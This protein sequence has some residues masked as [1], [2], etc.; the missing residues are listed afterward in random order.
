[1]KPLWQVFRLIWQAQR[2][3]LLRG[4]VL[5]VVVL[6]AGVTLLGV[7]GWFITAAAAAGLAGLGAVFDVFRPSGSIRFLALGRTAARY[8]ERVL[9]H[10]ATLR[11]FATL[12]LRVLQAYLAAPYDRQSRLRGPQVLNRITADI[13]A[14]DG[15]PLRLIL[16]LIAGGV[17]LAASFVVLWA[18]AGIAIAGVVAVGFALGGAV[19]LIWAGRAANTPSRRVEYAAQAFRARLIDLVQARGDLAVYGQLAAQH[20]AVLSAE[21]RR[22][23]AR[24]VQDRIERRAGLALSWLGTAIAT[25]ALLLG[26]ALADRGALSA[27]VA[28]VG[29]FASLALTEVLAPLRRAV[30]DLGRM[31]L[32]ARR[33]VASLPAPEVRAGSSHSA[34]PLR[35]EA[36]SLQRAGAARASLRPLG[37]TLH[38]GE[39]LALTGPSGVGKSTALLLAAGMLRPSAGVITLGAHPL[40]DWDEAALRAKVAL[41]PQRAGLMAGSI[42]AALQLAAPDADDAALWAVL[43]AVALGE[44]IRAKGGLDALLGPRGAGLSGGEA[45]RLAIA[46]VLLRR[47]AILLLDEPTEGLDTATALRVLHGIRQYLPQAAILTASHRPVETDWADFTLELS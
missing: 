15:L 23:D 45:R 12:R 14:L 1:M 32:A 24:L 27:A 19:V 20:Q 38:A 5:S 43:E 7:S 34:G 42:R 13:D 22:Q 41:L 46:R 10:D 35:F 18:I 40:P 37:F 11:A 30:A 33:V 29:F 36:V 28:A 25:A 17:T 31:R 8:G 6:V 44:V 26:M 9:T 39:T 21:A 47:P 4:A 16:P 3:S 2:A